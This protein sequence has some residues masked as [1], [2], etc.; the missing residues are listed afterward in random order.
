MAGGPVPLGCRDGNDQRLMRVAGANAAVSAV[1]NVFGI[2]MVVAFYAVFL[3]S[4]GGE[5]LG[6]LNDAAVAVQ[7]TLMLPIAVA[8]WRLLRPAG[9]RAALLTLAIGLFGMLTVI[10]LQL[11]LVFGVVPFQTQIFFVSVGFFITL[12]WFVLITRSGAGVPAV[13]QSMTL[14]VLAGLYVGYPVWAWML[15]RRLRGAE[16][17]AS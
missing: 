13:P 17:C 6:R 10:V 14:A 8:L 2:G 4:G 15:S 11:L 16:S 9:R 3:T 5:Q 12:A 1:V 7:Y